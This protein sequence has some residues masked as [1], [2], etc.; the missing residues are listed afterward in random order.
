MWRISSKIWIALA[1]SGIAMPSLMWGRAYPWELA[2]AVAAGIG[3]L[4]YSVANSIEQLRNPPHRRWRH[5]D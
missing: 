2:L 5:E 1:A 3:L 4:A